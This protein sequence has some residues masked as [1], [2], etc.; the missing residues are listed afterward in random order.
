MN[1][2]AIRSFVFEPEIQSYSSRDTMLYALALGMGDP[3]TDPRQLKFTYEADLQ[4]LP[5]MAVTLGAIRAWY[6]NEA[7]EI[8]WKR[9]LHG[10]ELLELMEPLPPAATVCGQRRV[11]DI[12]DRGEKGAVLYLHR[13]I[14]DLATG[15]LLARTTST[16]ILRGDGGFGGEAGRMPRPHVVPDR[17]PDAV[18]VFR[19]APQTAL[20]YRLCGDMNPLHADPA[21]AASAGFQAP[22]LH[23]LCSFG[24]AGRAVLQTVCELEPARLK[25]IQVRF[26]SPVFPGEEL[27]TQLWF[28]GEIISFRVI[29][30]DRGIV[31]I[32][33]GRAVV[34]A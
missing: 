21:I 5:T 14:S 16:M 6:K 10:E 11:G 17:E 15:R 19:T 25:Q 2:E 34:C 1:V 32:D 13:D 27:K 29:V 23:G 20:L 4:V 31:A 8:D 22:I 12:I 28:D 7:F 33:N 9:M 24:F 26:S 18:V 30:P 3:P